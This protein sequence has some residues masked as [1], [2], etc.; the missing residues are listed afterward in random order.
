MAPFLSPEDHPKKTYGKKGIK[1]RKT[2]NKLTSKTPLEPGLP[3]TTKKNAPED[4]HKT[5]L[6]GKSKNVKTAAKQ[7]IKRQKTPNKLTSKTPLEPASSSTVNKNVLPED[8][9][10]WDETV[11]ETS[12]SFMLKKLQ[13]PPDYDFHDHNICTAEELGLKYGVPIPACYS[14]YF[15]EEAMVPVKSSRPSNLDSDTFDPF[16][17]GSIEDSSLEYK[18]YANSSP[19][20]SSDGDVM[21]LKSKDAPVDLPGPMTR[22]KTRKLD[23]EWRKQVE[24]G[25]KWADSIELPKLLE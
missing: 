25:E 18:Q 21:S 14:K 24:E 12:A 3:S 6:K 15:D 23:E 16:S 22:S 20:L 1:R 17:W 5:V 8:D 19:S 4:D 11:S 2:R 9:E 13:L 10:L 7:R